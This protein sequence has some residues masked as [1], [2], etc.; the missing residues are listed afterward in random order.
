MTLSVVSTDGH[1]DCR[2]ELLYSL[3]VG[4]VIRISK[5]ASNT[6]VP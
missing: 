4:R 5:N 3:V 2:E 1:T 6:T